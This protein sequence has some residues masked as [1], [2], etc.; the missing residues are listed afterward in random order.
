[1]VIQLSYLKK[2]I[3]S[4]FC[5]ALCVVLP[6]AFHA[7]P[8]AGSIL[9]PMHIP[10]LLCGLICGGFFGGI[11]GIAGP[12]LSSLLTGMPPMAVLPCMVAELVAYGVISGLM[13]KFIR[14]QNKYLD[15]ILSLIIALVVGKIVAG[16]VTALFFSPSGFS[17]SVWAITYFV[18]SLPGIVIQF[19][20]IPSI[21][22]ALEKSNL[23]P[24]RY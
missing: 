3:I 17:L 14:V 6:L 16:I 4:S 12:L 21:I 9:S 2:N 19:I 18:T 15:L 13:M 7:I 22:F 24:R 10:V 11:C 5:V 8:N 20:I 1:M 23:I